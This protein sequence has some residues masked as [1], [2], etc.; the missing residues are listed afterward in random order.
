MYLLSL[1]RGRRRTQGTTGWSPPS[2]EWE[3]LILESISRHMKNKKVT[4][5]SQHDFTM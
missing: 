5:S 1:R 3:Q 2:L 4:R